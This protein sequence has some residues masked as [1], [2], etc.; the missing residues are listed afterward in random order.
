[1]AVSDYTSSIVYIQCDNCYKNYLD[2]IGI[3]SKT[4][5]VHL[6]ISK[7]C[8]C[9]VPKIKCLFTEVCGIY[10]KNSYTTESKYCACTMF[11]TVVINKLTY[12][13]NI[14]LLSTNYFE[15][16]DNGLYRDVVAEDKIIKSEYARY[17]KK[18]DDESSNYFIK[19]GD[20]TKV[21]EF[22]ELEK[23]TDPDN[24]FI[25]IYEYKCA[26]RNM[27]INDES[28]D[29][30]NVKY[31]KTE[32]SINNKSIMYNSVCS[33]EGYDSSSELNS[34]YSSSSEDENEDENEDEDENNELTFDNYVFCDFIYTNENDISI[35]MKYIDPTVNLSII[36]DVLNNDDVNNI[37]INFK[38]YDCNTL[39]YNLSF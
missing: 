6:Y 8:D 38:N 31:V 23:N 21:P 22:T 4:H 27:H 37:T 39:F 14:E 7:K 15:C 36:D 33:D 9:E 18:F 32:N 19:N 12:P 26:E 3:K 20:I 10:F 30:S 5:S 2:V 11:I 13:L 29:S 34:N 17:F 24:E 28:F 25:K 35:E 16:K 1:M